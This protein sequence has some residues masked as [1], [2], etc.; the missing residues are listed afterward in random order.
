MKFLRISLFL[1]IVTTTLSFTTHKFYV[2]ITKI[3]Y[4][5]EK[6]TLQIITKLFIDDIE[7]VLQARYDK[8]LIMGGESEPEAVGAYLEQYV[9]QKLEIEVN[10]APVKFHYL[11][12]EYENDVVKTFIEVKGVNELN[13][14]SVQN[15]MLFE[16]FEEQQNIVHI[17]RYKKRKSLVLD[18]DNPKGLLNF[19]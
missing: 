19:N 4:A 1:L 10:G 17:K 5:E 2:S 16:L 6:E 7:D 8:S 15:K 18:T 3:E 9:L 12:H 14:I 13:S 11:G